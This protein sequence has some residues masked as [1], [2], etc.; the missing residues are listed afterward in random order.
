MAGE[1]KEVVVDL[2]SMPEVAC[3]HCGAKFYGWSLKYNIGKVI[4]C[5]QCRGQMKLC[6][7][8]E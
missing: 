1:I 2:T 4:E 5:D 8:A 6:G 7:P 3:P